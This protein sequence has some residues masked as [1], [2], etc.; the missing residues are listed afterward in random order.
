MTTTKTRKPRSRK[1]PKT[2]SA[3]LYQAVT[4]RIIASLE[5]ADDSAWRAPW[6]GANASELPYNIASKKTYRGANVFTLWF[7]AFDKG[8][9]HGVWGTF[10]QW[11][12]VVAHDCDYDTGAKFCAKGANVRKG[13]HGT[14]IIFWKP[15]ETKDRDD[16][17]QTKKIML[18]RAYTVFNV[19][20]VDGYDMPAVAA[21]PEAERTAN[22]EAFFA[23]VGA[24][25]RHGGNR[26]FY[27]PSSD[28]IQLPD[29][30]DFRSPLDYYA[31]SAHEH[32]HW[33]GHESRNHR[34][35]SGRFGTDAYAFEELVAELGSAY[36]CATLGLTNEPR[37]DH[38]QYL[39]N[40][41]RV[42]K[43]DPQ[44]IVTAASAA[45]KA[46][47]FLHGLASATTEPVQD[48]TE[49]AA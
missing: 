20:Q 48:D 14:Q 40:W 11:H 24:D 41:L 30:A 19:D 25:V 3:D 21:K 9:G 5:A 13:E 47:D 38:A 32:V 1:A 44:A 31:T 35:F 27:L 16:P 4:D 33:T 28:R 29:F 36:V 39:K 2:T 37:E 26:A 17:E 22:A 23:A 6:H 43:S 49:V 10:R 45:Q 8:Y 18:A 12:N 34:D 46:V 7:E 15:W 42:L